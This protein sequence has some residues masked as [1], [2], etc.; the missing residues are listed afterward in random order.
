MTIRPVPKESA[1]YLHEL[2]GRARTEELLREA[3]EFR[4]ARAVRQATREAARETASAGSAA[5]S[6]LS[7]ARRSA[8]RGRRLRRLGAAG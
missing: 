2:L 1:M 7:G 4:L 8:R 6:A 3:E 5:S